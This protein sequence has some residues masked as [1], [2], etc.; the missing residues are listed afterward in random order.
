MKERRA[1]S[2]HSGHEMV[3]NAIQK[4]RKVNNNPLAH[5]HMDGHDRSSGQVIRDSMDRG[6]KMDP[7][8]P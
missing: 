4:V 8:K 2:K 6:P 3:H 7:Y 5:G 1:N